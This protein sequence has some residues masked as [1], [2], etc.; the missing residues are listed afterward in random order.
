MGEYPGM[1]HV[2]QDRHLGLGHYGVY[3]YLF[4]MCRGW[5]PNEV[6]CWTTGGLNMG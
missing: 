4:F 1:V 3:W 6:G 5:L 2:G